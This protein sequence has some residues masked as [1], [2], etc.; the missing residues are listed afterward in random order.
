MSQPVASTPRKTI[1]THVRFIGPGQSSE[2]VRVE[3]AFAHTDVAGFSGQVD[4]VRWH[5]EGET[6]EHQSW[7]TS[8]SILD[9]E[10]D[11]ARYRMIRIGAGVYGGSHVASRDLA[12]VT[13]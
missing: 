4:H 8:S 9:G 2:W 7:A 12:E 3:D 5:Y 1:Y 6:E 13:R 11:N 10:G